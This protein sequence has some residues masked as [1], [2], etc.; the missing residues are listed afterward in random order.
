[1]CIPSDI[2]SDGLCNGEG[3]RVKPVK[4][5]EEIAGEDGKRRKKDRMERRAEEGRTGEIRGKG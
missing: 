1:M 2:P 4:E 3:W 5:A